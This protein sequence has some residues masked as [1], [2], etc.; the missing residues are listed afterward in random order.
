MGTQFLAAGI[1]GLPI[2]ADGAIVAGGVIGYKLGGEKG[3]Y[4]GIAG[5]LI[6]M[7]AMAFG[8]D[9]GEDL[10]T[11]IRKFLTLAVGREAAENMARGVIPNGIASRLDASDLIFRKPDPSTT[12]GGAVEKYGTALLGPIIGGIGGEVVK[13]VFDISRGDTAEGLQRIIPVKQVRDMA[14]AWQ[15]VED[16]MRVLNTQ[17]QVVA[18]VDKADVFWK[19][20]G[21]NPS[22]V[23]QNREFLHAQRM[24]DQGL[25]E[26][27]RRVMQ[28]IIKHPDDSDSWGLQVEEYNRHAPDGYQITTKSIRQA[29]K[30]E[31]NNDGAEAEATSNKRRQAS[32]DEQ[33]GILDPDEE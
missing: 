5:T 30:R 7:A 16:D 10:D 25:A 17:G 33:L 8:D 20:M 24:L 2:F 28:K 26:R 1:L 13:A 6:A 18:D 11:E 22:T 15:W 14:Q 19:S 21:I 4:V 32:L 12:S 29:L 23:A 31:A 3:A 27:K 9:D